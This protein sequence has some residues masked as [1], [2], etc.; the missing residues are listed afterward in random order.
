MPLTDTKMKL[1]EIVV[2]LFLLVEGPAHVPLHGHHGA[3]DHC[4]IAERSSLSVTSRPGM[5]GR[6][7]VSFCRPKAS[8]RC[9]R[10]ATSPSPSA[11]ALLVCRLTAASRFDG[12]VGPM[13]QA[14]LKSD[15]KPA[16]VVATWTKP[17]PS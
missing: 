12:W 4:A 7:R 2:M 3:I 8:G 11:S 6:G 5:T 14:W 9:H 16:Y 10:R 15:R 17:H 1:I 13:Y